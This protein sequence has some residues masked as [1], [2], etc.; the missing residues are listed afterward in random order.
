MSDQKNFISGSARKHPSYDI[1]NISF[2]LE[3]VAKLPQTKGY[4]KIV[5]AKRKEADKWG[6]EYMIYEDTWKPENKQEE[7]KDFVDVN[8]LPF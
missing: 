6:N 2:K 5:V 7:K 3:D 8:D 4:V 1:M